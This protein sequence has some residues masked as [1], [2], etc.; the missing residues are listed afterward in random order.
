MPIFL[1][2]GIGF[3]K[4]MA[5]SIAIPTIVSGTIIITMVA[6]AFL[7]KESLSWS[8]LIGGACIILGIFILQLGREALLS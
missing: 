1:F 3:E 4:P 5:A 6:S 8:Q 2:G 7:L